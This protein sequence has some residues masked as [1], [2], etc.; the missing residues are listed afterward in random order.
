M[1]N[2]T[3]GEDIETKGG[4]SAGK[5]MDMPMRANIVIAS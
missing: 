2:G 5:T 1:E 3:N 4:G